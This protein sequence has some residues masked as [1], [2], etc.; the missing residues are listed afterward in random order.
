MQL[1]KYYTC[2]RD[3]WL[4]CIKNRL[5]VA[6]Y[7][8]PSLALQLQL[9]AKLHLNCFCL[10]DFVFNI[11]FIGQAWVSLSSAVDKPKRNWQ[12]SAQVVGREVVFASVPSHPIFFFFFL[13]R[14]RLSFS[15]VHSF[16]SSSQFN[17]P[18]TDGKAWFS[19]NANISW[20][21]LCH[22]SRD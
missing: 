8:W 17:G 7:I 18:A 14:F 9:S 11:N 3:P 2:L 22:N 12:T 15:L 19:N 5:K 20:W 6:W 21:E 16:Y 10:S 4:V 1:Y 13:E